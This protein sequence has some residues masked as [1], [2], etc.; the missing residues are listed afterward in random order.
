MYRKMYLIRTFEE[1]AE[2]LYMEG[3]I[4]GTFHLYVGEEAVA[5]GA[6][7]ALRADDY[8]TSTHRG[9]GHCIAKGADVKRM[10]AELLARD[11][12]YCHGL[13]GSMHIADVEKGNLG[14]TG[15]VGSGIP[16]ATGAALG[17]KL[18][19][20]DKVVLCF[21]GDGAAN[22]GA[23]HESV[24]MAAIFNLP[25]VFICEN[26]MYAMSFPAQK[27]FALPDIAERAKGYGIPGVSIDGNNV[28]E[29]YET[30]QIAI[31][32]ARQGEGPTFIEARTYR[33]KGHSKSDRQAYRTKEEV[34]EWMN[35][36][37]IKFL[38]KHLREETVR[39][40]ELEN[41]KKQVEREIE[42]AIN[43]ALESPEPTLEEARRMVYA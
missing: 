25:V 21:F 40:E 26:N 19:K 2:E 39:E 9:H 4:W 35:K 43:F 1:R 36:D 20:N 17:C 28:L 14:A 42:E 33:W 30:A 29:V 11:T 34:R 3:K 22:T 27:A 13:G 12:G 15:I 8:I 38:E 37:P 7:Y 41:I 5:V 31:E 6:C 10:M 23:F 18:Q 16:I 24:N 32:R